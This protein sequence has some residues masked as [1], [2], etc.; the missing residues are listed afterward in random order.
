MQPSQ[1]YTQVAKKADRSYKAHPSCTTCKVDYLGEGTCGACKF[2]AN[3]CADA[4]I[5]LNRYAAVEPAADDSRYSDEYVG[6]LFRAARLDYK[7]RAGL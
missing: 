4:V 7:K 5:V 3:L 6:I 2:V 1:T